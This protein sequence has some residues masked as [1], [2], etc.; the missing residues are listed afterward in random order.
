MDI[1]K[2]LQNITEKQTNRKVISIPVW[3]DFWN[4]YR[5]L[6]RELKEADRRISIHELSRKKLGEMLDDLEKV[7]TKIRK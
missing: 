2:E 3:P 5:S 6:A 4:R 1:K 7:L